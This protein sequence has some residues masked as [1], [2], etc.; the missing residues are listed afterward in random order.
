[1]PD[2]DRQLVAHPTMSYDPSGYG[3]AGTADNIDP[4][5]LPLD[6]FVDYE[7]Y[8]ESGFMT[9][10]QYYAG[11]GAPFSQAESSFSA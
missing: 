3:L 2:Q 6:E 4:G 5:D 11:Q 9:D 8:D 10:Q 7:Q 1:V